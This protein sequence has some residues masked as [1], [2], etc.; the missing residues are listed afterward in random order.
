M[1]SKVHQSQASEYGK[2]GI[3]CF[4]GREIAIFSWNKPISLSFM[5]F[6]ENKHN[7]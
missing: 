5:D 6:Y 2:V 3:K 7:S 4:R 1:G